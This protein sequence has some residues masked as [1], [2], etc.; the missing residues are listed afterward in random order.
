MSDR[1]GRR[2]GRGLRWALIALAIVIPVPL[3][4]FAVFALTFDPDSVKPRIEQAVKRATGRDL[5][6]NGPLGLKLSLWPT[7][8]ARDVALANVAGGSRPQMVTLQRLEAQVALLPLLHRSIEVERLVL[9]DPDILLETD[10]QG[11]PNWRFG[12]EVPSEAL[13]QAEPHVPAAPLAVAVR[14]VT[15]EGGR[16]TWHD[17]RTGRTV[18]VDL[19]DASLRAD[20]TDGPINLALHAAYAGA[21]FTLTGETG[22]LAR[23]RDPQATTP[24]PVR[25]SLGAANSTLNLDGALSHPQEGRGFRFK[26]DGVVPDLAA[27][28]ALSPTTPLPPLR[29][30][31]FSGEVA[32]AGGAPAVSG[33]TLRAGASD[34]AR[35][36]PGLRLQSLQA[37]M[38]REGEPV[39]FAASGALREAAFTVSGSLAREGATG[40]T[41]RDLALTTPAGAIA[42]EIAAGWGGRPTLHATL[43]SQRL[44]GDALQA[45][46]RPPPP[47]APAASPPAAGSSPAPAAPTAATRNKRVFSDRPIPFA[48]LREADADLHLSAATVRS[49]GQDYHDLAGHLVLL[50]GRLNVD[51]IGGRLPA[52]RLDGRVAVDA[53]GPDAAVALTLRGPG[54]QIAPLLALLKLPA[55]ARGAADIDADLRGTGNSPHALA[56]SADGH[57]GIAG[58]NG[59]IDNQLLSATLGQVLQHARLPD[60]TAH[61]GS[62]PV[63]CFAVRLDAQTGVASVRALLL[64]TSLFYLEGSG[65]IN[66]A[67]ETLAMRLRPLARLGGTGVIVPLR[68][69]GGLRAPKV[70]VD[71]AGA[72]GEAAGIAAQAARSPQ[73]G[74]IIGALGGDNMVPGSGAEDCGHQLAIARGGLPGPAPTAAPAPAPSKPPKPAD[75]LRQLLR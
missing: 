19:A 17:G 46:L 12:P 69:S 51:P 47:P 67:D 53:T 33:L 3:I 7:L 68:L 32:D 37:D 61:P 52:G 48:L 23:F 75:L 9:V 70:E 72:A 30:V 55:G 63:R 8:E 66:L 25:L 42:G 1:Q 10:A 27:L 16:L 21:P 34:L 38:A 6:L 41:V 31:R 11:R 15:V 60:I 62:L 43:T 29:D 73:L 57:L 22:S 54:L 5:A 50:N 14:Q 18:A 20:G 4:G 71:A 26:L 49:G 74:V 35:F 39:R 13:P 58:V 28:S 44:D 2:R 56:A 40:A 64:D 65:S 36:V 24:W 59:E 45:A